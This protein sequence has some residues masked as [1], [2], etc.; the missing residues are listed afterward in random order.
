MIKALLVIA[1]QARLQLFVAV[2]GRANQKPFSSEALSQLFFGQV[3]Q[4]TGF[5]AKFVQVAEHPQLVVGVRTDEVAAQPSVASVAHA[6]LLE[7]VSGGQELDLVVAIVG[8]AL[9]VH[10][11][12]DVLVH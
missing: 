9:D 1:D 10:D 4:A 2:I 7:H 12:V 11:P 3:S 8:I 5:F 6:V